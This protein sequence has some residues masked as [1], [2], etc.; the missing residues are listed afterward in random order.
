M[1]LNPSLH[2]GRHGGPLGGMGFPGLIHPTAF[3]I[4]VAGQ[5]MHS[6]A[7]TGPHM[8]MLQ[9]CCAVHVVSYWQ[10]WQTPLNR[11][12]P[13]EPFHGLHWVL[14]TGNWQVAS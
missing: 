3:G 7:A 11:Y 10:A 9:Y 2:T 14:H 4:T 1:R 5:G 6:G 12:Q 8:A 13:T